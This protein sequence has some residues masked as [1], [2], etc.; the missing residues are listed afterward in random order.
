[1]CQY[2]TKLVENLYSNKMPLIVFKNIWYIFFFFFLNEYGSEIKK[3]KKAEQNQP[4][5]HID[6]RLF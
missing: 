2:L 3:K 4:C 5:L 6:K 1:M